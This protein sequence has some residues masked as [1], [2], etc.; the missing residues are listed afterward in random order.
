MTNFIPEFVKDYS[1][2]NLTFLPKLP[3]TLSSLDCSINKLNSLPEL[4]CT[5]KKLYCWDNHNQLTFPNFLC[6]SIHFIVLTTSWFFFPN[7]LTH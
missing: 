1:G 6:F 2:K 5:L 3:F 4:P 7:F